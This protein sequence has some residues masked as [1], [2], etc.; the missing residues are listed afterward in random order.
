MVKER[1]ENLLSAEELEEVLKGVEGITKDA[2]ALRSVK[3]G[4]NNEPFFI[5]KPFLKGA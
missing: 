3:L 5:F 1:Y 4:N 2:E